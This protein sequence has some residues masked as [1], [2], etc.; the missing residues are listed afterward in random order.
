MRS[1]TMWYRTKKLNQSSEL[2]Y[3]FWTVNG[4]GLTSPNGASP[5]I[6]PMQ[7][8]WVRANSGGGTLAL[9]NSMRSHAPDT[10][11]LLKAP[12]AKNTEMTLVRLQVSNGTNNDEAVIYFSEN[13]QNDVDK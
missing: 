2:V 1:T 8:F 6:P 12:A 3:Q 13:A 5:K 10:D 9:T 11:K 7:A 4:D